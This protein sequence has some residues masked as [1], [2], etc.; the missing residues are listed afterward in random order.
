MSNE[1]TTTRGSF[2][3]TPKSLDEAMNFAQMI[4]KANIVP[5]DFQGNPG[6]II[7][8]LQWGAEIGLGP[9]QAMQNIAII[10]GRPALWGD[11]LIALARGSGLLESIDEQITDTVATCTIKRKGEQATSRTFSF[12][13][14][15]HA[16][17]AGKQGPWSQ[18]PKRMMQMRAR[19]WAL[20][21][22]FPDVLRGVNV[23]EEAQDMPPVARDMGNVDQIP[24][25]AI[26]APASRA[27][28]AR[29]A[30]QKVSVESVINSI[31]SA[32]TVVE[33]K[34][35]SDAAKTLSDD[36]KALARAAYK[37]RHAQLEPVVVDQKTG[38]IEPA[39]TEATEW[40]A[41]YNKAEA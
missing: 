40:L 8:A 31:N 41:D 26:N 20:R 4:S 28:R 18:Y 9:L 10:N 39:K 13:D 22:V 16:G 27:A 15:K 32:A 35:A 25:V 37:A 11:A 14:A 38:E 12:E 36:D 17:L 33:L 19:A 3:L 23:A 1:I 2:N 7:V 34:A 24:P 6:N 5:K 29:A 21:D 30:V